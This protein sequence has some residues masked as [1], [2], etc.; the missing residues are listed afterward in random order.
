M[1][2]VYYGHHKCSSTFVR[3]AVVRPLCLNHNIWYKN[4]SIPDEGEFDKLHIDLDIE[5][6]K[7]HDNAML[8]IANATHDAVKT[9]E[10]EFPEHRAFHVYRDPRNI[11]ISCVFNHLFHKTGGWLELKKTKEYFEKEEDIEKRALFELDHIVGD[12]LDNQLSGWDFSNPKIINFKMENLYLDT[13]E[14]FSNIF[15]FLGMK[16]SDDSLRQVLKDN[17]WENMKDKHFFRTRDR[18]DWKGKFTTKMKEIF[19]ERYGHLLIHLGY[20]KGTDW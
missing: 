12:I 16:I 7:S 17:T 3:N 13:Y 2:Y 1:I 4:Y 10:R 14:N 11:L 8:M 15:K 9:V 20:E 5:N 19:K 18:D 6:I